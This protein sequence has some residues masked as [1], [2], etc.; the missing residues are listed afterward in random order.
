MKLGGIGMLL[1][2]QNGYRRLYDLFGVALPCTPTKPGRQGVQV[3]AQL[4]VRRSASDLYRIWRNLE[5]LPVFMDHLVSV[6][7]I[8]DI[9]SQWIAKA[10][11]GM[12]IKWEAE[13]VRDEEDRL[14]AWQ[15]LEGSGVDSAGSVQFETLDASVSLVHVRLKYNPPAGRAGAILA[16][17]FM[18]DP[19][20]QI[21]HDLKRFKA[22][23]E[24]ESRVTRD[25]VEML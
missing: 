9:R 24:L 20:T 7:E 8:D 11:A 17:A 13:I 12:V 18:S 4:V 6:R 5:N 2:G 3:D 16:R 23:V 14:I 1:R 21:E 15:S 19:Q 22:I 25:A 10:P